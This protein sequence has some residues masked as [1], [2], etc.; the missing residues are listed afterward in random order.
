[1][2]GDTEEIEMKREM[3]ESWHTSKTGSEIFDWAKVSDDCS[4]QL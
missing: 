2:I 4:E 3:I 1:M